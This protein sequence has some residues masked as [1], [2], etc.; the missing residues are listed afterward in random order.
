MCG[1][2]GVR[3]TLDWYSTGVP[4]DRMGRT[5][6]LRRLGELLGRVVSP[7]G[8]RVAPTLAG[9]ALLISAA[10]GA[11][12]I[13][14]GVPDARTAITA[15]FPATAEWDPLEGEPP[16]GADA[17]QRPVIVELPGSV[18]WEA[19]SWWFAAVTSRHHRRRLSAVSAVIHTQRGPVDVEL[20]GVSIRASP[21]P[22][23]RGAGVLRLSFADGAVAPRPATILKSLV[24]VSSTLHPQ[25][26]RRK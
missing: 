3:P 21:I 8:G 20:H 12:R 24:A 10:S 23:A 19:F 16:G 25:I 17:R 9:T 5:E 7:R 6:S 22:T 14:N 13:A 11:S 26:D 15:L 4:T 2:C 1:A 18:H